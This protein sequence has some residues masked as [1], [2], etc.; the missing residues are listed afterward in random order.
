MGCQGGVLK[1]FGVEE[2]RIGK[3]RGGWDVKDGVLK[4]TGVKEEGVGNDRGGW[5]V[6]GVL[7]R[8]GV[9]DGVGKDRGGWDAKEG[10]GGR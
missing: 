6:K 8:I 5:D 10:E 3:D 1:R 4:K 9:N 7:K 2:E